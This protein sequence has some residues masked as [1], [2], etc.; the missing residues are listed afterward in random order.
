[1]HGLSGQVVTV[2]CLPL[3][4]LQTKVVVILHKRECQENIS[5]MR[6]N[7]CLSFSQNRLSV[8]CIGKASKAFGCLR[9]TIF[10]VDIC[11]LVQ[12]GKF[13]KPFFTCSIIQRR[14]Q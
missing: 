13:M 3:V 4:L 14:E 12:R 7:N 8:C 6:K 2:M 5:E 10:E 1:M 11:Q 9:Q